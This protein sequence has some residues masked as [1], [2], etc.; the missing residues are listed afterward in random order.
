MY[1]AIII[2]DE[3]DSR[4]TIYSYVNGMFDDISIVGEAENVEKG[5]LLINNIDPDLIFLDI[6]MPDGT[7]F[8]LL[9]SFKDRNLN[10]IFITAYDQY[11]VRAFKFSAVD[12]LLKPID[13]DY[14][15]EAL[16]KFRSKKE[17]VSSQNRL[18]NFL[19]N[20]TDFEKISLPTLEGYKFIDIKSIL[21]CESSGSYTW[22]YTIN[23]GSFLVSRQIKEYEEML[24]DLGFFRVHQSHLI[25]LRYLKEYKKGEGGV[26]VLNDNIEIMVA[27]RRKEG[28]LAAILKYGQ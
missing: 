14:L 18:F 26:V 15:K 10:V 23:D 24:V 20:R 19:Q 25:N 22:F 12:Y 28:L 8:D 27:R 2:D 3:Q 16:Q 1:R 4:E 11:A 5:K 13:P 21:R 6:N 17:L 7:G 9:E